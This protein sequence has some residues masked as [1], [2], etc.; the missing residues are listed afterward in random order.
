MNESKKHF[1]DRLLAADPPS[2]DGRERYAKEVRAMLEKTLTPRERGLYLVSAVVL[3]L[4]AVY[5]GFAAVNAPLGPEFLKFIVAYA[6]VTAL[7][8]LVL[9]G[10]LFWAYWKGVV[11]HGTSR[12]WA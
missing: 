1:V 5:L 2:P 8:L 6:W 10:L 4:M 9:A 12:R 11:T 3:V 7:A